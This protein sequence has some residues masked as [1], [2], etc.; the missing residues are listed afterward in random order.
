MQRGRIAA[1]LD[2]IDHVRAETLVTVIEDHLVTFL[3]IT[4]A[5]LVADIA[6]I[7]SAANHPIVAA[8]DKK[9]DRPCLP[10]KAIETGL[11]VIEVGYGKTDFSVLSSSDF[12]TSPSSAIAA[13]AEEAFNLA[14]I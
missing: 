9:V 8:Y 3:A 11:T 5:F 13:M 10:V 6:G 12:L 4:L 7:E 14:H 2:H 1:A